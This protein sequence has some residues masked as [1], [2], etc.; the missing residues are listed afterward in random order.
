MATLSRLWEEYRQAQGEASYQYSRFCDLY[1]EF[2][3][4]LK[5]S[6]RQTHRAGER[7]F[8]HFA[9]DTVPLVDAGSGEIWRAHVFVA[10]LGASN[11][12]YACA[13]AAE[14]QIDWLGSIG[15]ALAFIGGVPALIVP[16][17]PRALAGEANAYDPKLQRT[18]TEFDVHY[19]SRRKKSQP[20]RVGFQGIGGGGGN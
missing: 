16:D 7:L 19:S 6:M 11:Y 17:N 13:T 8:V 2:A 10:V 12:T 5:R 14:G 20:V 1:R 18:V 15:R 9:G 4:G 3:R